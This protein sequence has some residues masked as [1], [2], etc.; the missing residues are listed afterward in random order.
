L[1]SCHIPPPSRPGNA[2][3]SYFGP[4]AMKTISAKAADI[5]TKWYLIDAENLVLGRMASICAKILRG[6]HKPIFTPHVDCGDGI[7]VINAAKVAMTGTKTTDKVYYHHTG[8]PGGIKSVT[9]E[10]LIADGKADRIVMKAVE[11]MLPKTKLGRQQL[12][13]LRVFAGPEHDHA[14]QNPEVL[15]VAAMNSK[16]KRSA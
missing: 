14:A 7:I 13:K 16:N 2:G 9:P 4:I 15:D 1:E 6:K 12:T 3:A 11:R 8:Y 10:K 5:E